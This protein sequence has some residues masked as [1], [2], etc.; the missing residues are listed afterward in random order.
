MISMIPYSDIQYQNA[1]KSYM[2]LLTHPPPKKKKKKNT[3]PKKKK[4]KKKENICSNIAAILV[5]RRGVNSL[6]L[7]MKQNGRHFAD[8]FLKIIF[9]YSDSHFTEICSKGH[10]Q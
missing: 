2:S 10:Q 6:T 3:P 5:L 8:D 9:L 4:K 1:N 7:I